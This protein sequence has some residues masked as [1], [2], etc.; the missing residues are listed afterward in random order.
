VGLAWSG[1]SA[2]AARGSRFLLLGKR[3]P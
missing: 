1:R 3:E 2:R